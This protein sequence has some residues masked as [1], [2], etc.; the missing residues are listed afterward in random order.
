MVG[1]DGLHTNGNNT[2]KLIFLN[3]AM[4]N[5]ITHTHTQIYFTPV[6]NNRNDKK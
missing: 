2:T 4:A 5:F 6:K 3:E 1:G